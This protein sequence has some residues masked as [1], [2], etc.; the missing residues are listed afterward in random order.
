M[1]NLLHIIQRVYVYFSNASVK[2]MRPFVASEVRTKGRFHLM[3]YNPTCPF[4][5]LDKITYNS[6]IR[7]LR[8][9]EPKRI[10]NAG[11]SSLECC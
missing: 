1:L 2:H 6:P 5:K 10:L 3:D 7:A 9:T 4:L 11:E 8:Q